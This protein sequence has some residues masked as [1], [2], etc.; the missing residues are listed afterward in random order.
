ML[1]KLQHTK[2]KSTVFSH[3]LVVFVTLSLVY[4]VVFV[5]SL[6]YLRNISRKK[7]TT[8][9]DSCLNR[10]IKNESLLEYSDQNKTSSD[11]IKAKSVN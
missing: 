4:S 9:P 10:K 2:N 3:L 1:Y 7:H 8:I 5:Q 6:T 11:A